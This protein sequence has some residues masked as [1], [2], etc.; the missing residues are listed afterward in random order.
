MAYNIRCEEL[1]RSFMI[2]STSKESRVS[3]LQKVYTDGWPR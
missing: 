1:Y 3:R 2:Y